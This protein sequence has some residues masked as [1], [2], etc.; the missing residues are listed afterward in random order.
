IIARTGR[1]HRRTEVLTKP[2][3]ALAD[4][5]NRFRYRSRDLIKPWPKERIILNLIDPLL[6]SFAPSLIGL[7]KS[8]VGGLNM[9]VN[10]LLTL[11]LSQ[12]HRLKDTANFL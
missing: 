3:I 6:L 11:L 4:L 2:G 8:F 9:E 12:V 5:I 10:K 7:I 1:I